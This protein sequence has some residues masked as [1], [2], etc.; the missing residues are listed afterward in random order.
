[1]ACLFNLWVAFNFPFYQQQLIF[2]SGSKS[3][4]S[5]HIDIVN[6]HVII[7]I[8]WPKCHVH[9]LITVYV[10]QGAAWYIPGWVPR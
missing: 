7:V 3:G 2:G 9:G 6:S 1:M 10:T 5:I 4:P 8:F